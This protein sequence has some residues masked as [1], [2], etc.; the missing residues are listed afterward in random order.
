MTHRRIFAAVALT[1]AVLAPAPA[2]VADH[3]GD[4]YRYREGCGRD[5]GG[6]NNER[7]EDYTNGRKYSPSFEDSP[8]HFAPVVCLPGSTCEF[9]DG[10]QEE[11]PPR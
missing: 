11:T 7:H 6:C 2:A 9:R 4:D 8:V 5:G 10:R 3:G 1:F